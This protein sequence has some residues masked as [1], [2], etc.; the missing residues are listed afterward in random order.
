MQCALIFVGDCLVAYRFCRFASTSV[1]VCEAEWFGQS[2][3]C[4]LLQGLMPALNFMLVEYRL[5]IISFCDCL[6]A[7]QI[8]ESESTN[9]RLKHVA[10]RMAYLQECTDEGLLAMVHIDTE[11]N[12][13]DIGTKILPPTAFHA[14]RS[15]FMSDF[16]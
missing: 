8:S 15:L 4:L 7:V 12:V 13:S 9:K 10:T 1:S 14:F 2:L 6:S 11:G 5:P 3:A 16:E